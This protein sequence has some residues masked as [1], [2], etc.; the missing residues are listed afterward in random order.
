MNNFPDHQAVH[1]GYHCIFPSHSH[2]LPTAFT[3]ESPGPPVPSYPF[4]DLQSR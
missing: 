3:F 2:Y 4:M 1:A